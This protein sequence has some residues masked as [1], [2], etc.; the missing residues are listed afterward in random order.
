[1]AVPQAVEAQAAEADRLLQ[2]LNQQSATPEATSPPAPEPTAQPVEDWETKYRT[3]QGKYNAEVP[4]ASRE[5]ATL[6]NE[7]FELRSQLRE[8]LGQVEQM[9]QMMSQQQQQKAAVTDESLKKLQ[10]DYG[11]N[12]AQVIQTQLSTIQNLQ[13]ELQHLKQGQQQVAQVA[14]QSREDMFWTEI[15][16][17]VPNWSQL[18]EDSRFLNWLNEPEGLSGYTRIQLLRQAQQNLDAERAARFFSAFEA[19][20][21]PKSKKAEQLAEIASPSTASATSSEAPTKGQQTFTKAYVTQFYNDA[22][23]NKY[24]KE[25]YERIDRDITKAMF[26]G[27]I[28]N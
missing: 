4:A 5:T 12:L 10:E 3:L 9:R 11:D 7:N 24:S 18:N 26:E 2:E 21:A 19:A 20:I 16:R 15:G 14:A 8:V 6:R 27:R 17:L 13:Q 22:K 23:L 1:M 28:T 25:E